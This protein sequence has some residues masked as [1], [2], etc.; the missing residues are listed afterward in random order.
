MM[1][2]MSIV[3]ETNETCEIGFSGDQLKKAQH[4]SVIRDFMGVSDSDNKQIDKIINTWI[5]EQLNKI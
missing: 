3:K 4:V 1:A 5:D 2:S